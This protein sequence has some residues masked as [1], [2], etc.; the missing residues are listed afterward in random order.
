MLKAAKKLKENDGQDSAM[1]LYKNEIE[2][3]EKMAVEQWKSSPAKSLRIPRWKS[4]L[5]VQS[6]V[7]KLVKFTKAGKLNTYQ[8]R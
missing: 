3:T 6:R 4:K 2:V 7:M 1:V 8:C 5:C